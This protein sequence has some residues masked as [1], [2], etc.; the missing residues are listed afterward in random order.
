MLTRS[1]RKKMEAAYKEFVDNEV[2][3]E[4]HKNKGQ[5]HGSY[6]VAGDTVSI[7]TCLTEM[8]HIL[9][10]KNVVTKDQ[11]VEA[12]AIACTDL[13]EDDEVEDESK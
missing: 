8:F 1:Q 12:L 9:M 13:T 2:R 4:C 11:L 5:K 7:L 3:V 10:N 6:L